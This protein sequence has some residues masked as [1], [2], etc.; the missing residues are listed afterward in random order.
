MQQYP[1]HPVGR[2]PVVHRQRDHVAV[3][4]RDALRAA[5]RAGGV[6][7]V[8]QLALRTGQIGTG[9]TLTAVH[10]EDGEAQLRCLGEEHGVGEHH[11]HARLGGDRP[12]VGQRV[13]RVQGHIEP[14]GLDDR[15]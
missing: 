7:H 9:G 8:R 11:S 15:Q 10:V 4:D 1:V 14:A 5:G 2:E 13:A 6:H 3:C 12:S